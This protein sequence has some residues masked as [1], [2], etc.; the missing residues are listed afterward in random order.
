MVWN[1]VSDWDGDPSTLPTEPLQGL[2]F[3]GRWANGP[4]WVDV[5][6][7]LLG[8]QPLVASLAGGANHAYTD[9]RLGAGRDS[10]FSVWTGEA[11]RPPRVPSI[12]SQIAAYAS[13]EG[14]IRDGDLAV[15][16]SG[17]NDLIAARSAR[18][19]VEAV[20]RIGAHIQSLVSLG[21]THIVVPNQLDASIAPFFAG[22][23]QSERDALSVLTATFNQ[24]LAQSLAALQAQYGGAVVLYP[25]DFASVGRDLFLCLSNPPPGGCFGFED[26]R[27]P[28]AVVYATEARLGLPVSIFDEKFDAFV[29]WDTIHPTKAIHELLGVVACQTLQAVAQV[30]PAAPAP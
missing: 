4:V 16:W 10:R 9:A 23:S 29:F 11:L 18:N 1:P 8:A 15:L 3:G 30:C 21:A 13:S 14:R 26:F 12:G 7:T 19:V 5:L 6:A 28:A 17:A 2:Y 24:L 20:V 22:L 27:T 25:V